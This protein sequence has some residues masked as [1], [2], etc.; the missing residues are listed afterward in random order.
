MS[1]WFE[2]FKSSTQHLHDISDKIIVESCD[3]NDFMKGGEF[4][5]IAN[6]KQNLQPIEPVMV[7]G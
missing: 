4:L 7:A 6:W 3:V 1:Q 2:K 5:Q